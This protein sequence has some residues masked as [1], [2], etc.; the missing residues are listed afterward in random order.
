MII[1]SSKLNIIKQSNNGLLDDK[2]IELK[3][4]E[5]II[6]KP[7]AARPRKKKATVIVDPEV[8][9]EKEEKVEETEDEV[10]S[11]WLKEEEEVNLTE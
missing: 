2:K 5:E 4:Q 9:I 6:E 10:L 7:A 8:K 11:R 1:R 3:V